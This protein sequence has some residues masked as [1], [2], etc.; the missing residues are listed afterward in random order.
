MAPTKR[1]GGEEPDPT[2][3]TETVT[4][5]SQISADDARTYWQGVDA[6]DD[7]MLGGYAMV[8]RVDLRGSRSFLA[9]L[10][11]GRKKGAKVIKRVLEGGAGIG[12][13][14]RGLLTEMAETVDV[15]EPVAKFTEELAECE[16]VGHVY[17]Q[18]LED[19]KPDESTDVRYDVIWIQWCLSYL[20]E[21]QLD[22]FLKRCKSVLST[23]DSGNVTGVI[24]VKEN[25]AT[26]LE[27]VFD[28]I[29]SGLT[30]KEETFR[31]IFT[32]AGLKIIKTELQHGLPSE[33]FPVRMFALKPVSEEVAGEA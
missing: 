20:N 11:F 8:S 14:T 19:W 24:V 9:K 7:G 15:V 10:G 33:L 22:A 12:R 3:D 18:G 5:D 6:D 17:N 13:I 2:E 21:V 28:A 23:D 1:K 26:G 16:G 29:D 30:R 31:R 32:K 4:P 25:L 27:D